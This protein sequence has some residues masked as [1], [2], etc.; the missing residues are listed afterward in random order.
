MATPLDHV[1]TIG[2]K[3]ID[4]CKEL[5]R[6]PT[7]NPPGVGYEKMS[8]YLAKTLR[9]LNCEVELV[10][11]PQS[12]EDELYPFGK[13]NP[14]ISVIGRYKNSRRER[15]GL[16]LSGHYDTVPP[17]KGW[18]KDPFTPLLEGG[19]IYGLG[20][21]DMKGGIASVLGVIRALADLNLQLRADLT[22]SFT[23]DEETGGFAG[24]GYLVEQKL[25]KADFGIITEPA[26]PHSVKVGHRGALWVE[27]T[28]HGKTAH[29]SVPY[30][31]VNAFQKIVDIAQG[32]RELEERLYQKR[33]R[34]PVIDEAQLSPP[35][36]VGGV[37]Q[38]GVKTNVVPDEC[39][40]TIDRR[41]I[42]E[43]SI[44]EAYQE[45]EEAIERVKQADPQLRVDLKKTLTIEPSYV[46]QDHQ[47]CSAVAAAHEQVY[48]Q[49]PSLVISPGFADAHY[50]TRGL[51][52]P[53][54]TY[55]PG[56][57]GQAHAPDEHI[58]PEDLVKAAKVL[59]Q[60]T[61]DLVGS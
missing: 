13:G 25:V 29:G 14:R 5:V 60:T 27:V 48:G 12:R 38:G 10:R 35:V 17:G 2:E 49:R 53:T 1:D 8:D 58:Y 56:I 28:T 9:G 16:H 54:I 7:V 31:G 41:L 26:Q 52:I 33:T 19:K 59:L 51:R 40:V 42:I 22:F 34:F 55:G 4:Y 57:L 37:V 61:L 3:I 24:V 11:V 50:F 46:P 39:M 21:S 15:A 6:I 45:I 18:S 36:M 23:P 44:A 20:I 32:L 47:I 30:R 43:E